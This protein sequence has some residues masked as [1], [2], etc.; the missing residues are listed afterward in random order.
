M[1]KAIVNYQKKSKK[2]VIGIVIGGIATVLLFLGAFIWF[3]W[4]VIM[5][6]AATVTDDIKDYDIIFNNHVFS[7][8]MVFPEKVPA[9]AADTEFCYYW[10]DTL[11][12]PTCQIYMSCKY[13][14]GDFEAE[15]NRI[16]NIKKIVSDKTIRIR[17]DNGKHFEYPT[18]AAINNYNHC[19]EYA[20]L[21]EKESR[22]VYVF[23]MFVG[24]EKVRF[25]KKYLPDN[26]RD[27]A[28][29][30]EDKFTLY[31]VS[32]DSIG[33]TLDYSRDVVVPV[34]DAHVIQKGYYSMCVYTVTEAN[35]PE[36]IRESTL[37]YFKPKT[38][39][40]NSWDFDKL[41]GCKYISIEET[42]NGAKIVY[43]QASIQKEVYVDF[44][45][46]TMN[47]K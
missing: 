13:S 39:E 37:R 31:F 38:F 18:Y 28:M 46:H 10:R 19:Y 14:A 1:E 24:K 23:T 12:D 16:S 15:K 2:L 26:Y 21:I 36:I 29:K 47:V 32:S 42:E 17:E 22:I 43:E 5:G 34:K 9:S 30:E 25:P 27:E 41:N 35:G 20:T 3:M 45:S 11:F 33:T 7:G 44:E 8:L 6:P 4:M 40:E